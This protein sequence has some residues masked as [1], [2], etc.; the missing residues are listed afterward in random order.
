MRVEPFGGDSDALRRVV[1]AWPFKPYRWTDASE[2]AITALAL[3]RLQETICRPNVWTGVARS[4][5]SEICGLA[6]LEWLAWDSRMLGTEAS[7]LDFVVPGEYDRRRS[8][9]EALLDAAV[10]EAKARQHRHLS[11]RVD[12]GDVAAI[13]ALEA[14]GWLLVD[15]LL[16]FERS[17]IGNRAT[18]AAFGLTLRHGTANDS[19]S[20][21]SI[22]AEAFVDGRF[23][24]DPSIAPAVATS[25]YREWA[26]ACCRGEAA[27]EIIVAEDTFGRIVGFVASRLLADTGADLR[28][29]TASIVLIAT[30]AAARGRGVGAALID[31]ALD[32]AST[33]SALM[34]QV[35]TQIRNVAAARLYERRGFRLASAS[36]SF[37][38]VIVQ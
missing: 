21:E 25:I 35:G 12:A 15:T 6:T 7:R 26:A 19:P 32:S 20:I 37:R 34:V 1:A 2:D 14:N 31:A 9:Y 28:R 24:A 22:A 30:S 18:T 38:A 10:S 13:H 29:L 36:Q 33:H 8:A 27:D 23:H 16:T 4:D 3:S 5:D 17:L 11:A